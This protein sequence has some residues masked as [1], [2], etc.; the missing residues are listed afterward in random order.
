MVL[1]NVALRKQIWCKIFLHGINRKI[2][3]EVHPLRGIPINLSPKTPV[4]VGL[5]TKWSIEN[6]TVKTRLAAEN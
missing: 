2:F 3:W 4:L 5:S 1:F 6:V